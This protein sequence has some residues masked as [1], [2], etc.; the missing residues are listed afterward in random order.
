MGGRKIAGVVLLVL[1]IIVLV[2]SLAADLIGAGGSAAFGSKQIIGTV[3][4]AIVAVVGLV[5]A[6]K[7]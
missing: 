2:L 5:L 6:L 4:G 3:V 1:G 7:K